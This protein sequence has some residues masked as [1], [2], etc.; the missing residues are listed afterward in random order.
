[1]AKN[2]V[3]VIMDLLKQQG[4]IAE[5]VFAF[6][7]YPPALGRKSLLII[8]CSN[9]NLYTDPMYFIPLSEVGFWQFKLNQIAVGDDYSLCSHGC[10]AIVDSGTTLIAGPTGEIN[11][12]NQRLKAGN[13]GRAHSRRMRSMPTITFK[14]YDRQRVLRE[15]PLLPN[16]YMRKVNFRFVCRISIN[17]SSLRRDAEVLFIR[18]ASRGSVW[19][20]AK[21]PVTFW[22]SNSCN[23]TSYCTTCPENT[24]ALLERSIK[25]KWKS[26]EG[27]NLPVY[28]SCGK[29]MKFICLFDEKKTS[30]N[31]TWNSLNKPKTKRTERKCRNRTDYNLCNSLNRQQANRKDVSM[32][33]HFRI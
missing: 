21:S 28:A 20:L 30:E 24:S 32:T 5:R 23:D 25:I 22:A 33:I 29:L 26:I 9:E 11:K 18:P 10:Q 19:E 14:M 13:N 4:A 8:G 31:M 7:M 2:N 6:C 3:P 27:H 12:L 15:F 1:M 16:E 17:I